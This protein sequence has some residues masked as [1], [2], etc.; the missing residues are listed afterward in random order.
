MLGVSNGGR[1]NR[2]QDAFAYRIDYQGKNWVTGKNDGLHPAD[3]L[4]SATYA[5]L[6]GTSF[7]PMDLSFAYIL[8]HPG[9]MGIWTLI[10]I[11]SIPKQPLLFLIGQ[12]PP[13]RFPRGTSS[14]EPRQKR[15][16]SPLLRCGKCRWTN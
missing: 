7:W 1:E 9:R 13:M 4:I 15:I 3:S 12:M 6:L 5:L 14:S 16:K 8:F 11:V 10:K 2:P